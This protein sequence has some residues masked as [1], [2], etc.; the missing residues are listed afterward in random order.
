MQA[1]RPKED[2]LRAWSGH[3]GG[4]D[5]KPL[6]A[7]GRRADEHSLVVCTISIPQKVSC[8]RE[9]SGAIWERAEVGNPG[10]RGQPQGLGKA[11]GPGL[12]SRSPRVPQ[13]HML[14]QELSSILGNSQEQ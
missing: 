9:R 13:K 12:M 14:S 11:Q 4:W 6:K 1:W 10:E 5:M 7:K 8:G 2:R 3:R